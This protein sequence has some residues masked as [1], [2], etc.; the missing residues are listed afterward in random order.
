MLLYILTF[1][2]EKLWK[3]SL[4]QKTAKRELWTYWLGLSNKNTTIIMV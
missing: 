4:C 1:C 2:E 3:S